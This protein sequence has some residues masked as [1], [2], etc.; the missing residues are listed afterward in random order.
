MLKSSGK[1]TP[2]TTTI[3]ISWGGF[4]P[5]KGAA[6]LS[7]C[8][9]LHGGVSQFWNIVAMKVRGGVQVLLEGVKNIKI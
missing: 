5:K 9:N 4:E 7:R 1:T 6:G 2:Y 3:G 8:L